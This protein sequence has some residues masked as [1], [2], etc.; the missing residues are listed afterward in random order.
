MISYIFFISFFLSRMQL[1]LSF[2]IIFSSVFFSKVSWRCVHLV[3][4]KNIAYH[5]LFFPTIIIRH[6]KGNNKIVYELLMTCL[7]NIF[8]L[9]SILSNTDCYDYN[10]Q[11]SLKCE[12]WPL[13]LYQVLPEIRATREPRAVMAYWFHDRAKFYPTSCTNQ[14]LYIKVS[15]DFDS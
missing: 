4:R 10:C 6:H 7:T 1:P 14:E 3:F 8:Y 9:R 5:F 13:P 15:L 2:L 12:H 11:L